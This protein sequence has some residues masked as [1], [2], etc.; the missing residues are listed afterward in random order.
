MANLTRAGLGTVRDANFPTN[1]NNEITASDLRDW[2]TDGIDSFLTQKDKNVM[3]EVIWEAKSNNLTAGATTDL[4]LANGNFVHITGT[5]TTINSFGICDAGSRF[6]LVF[7][8]IYTL[9]YDATQL[10]LPGTANITTANND[11]CMIMSEGSGN[12]RVVGYF[13]IAGGGGGGTV[14]AVTAT[15]P[16]ASSG[17]S[18]PDISIQQASA[19][20]D[21]YLSSTDWNTFDGKQDAL[22][23]G[24]GISLAS[25]TV[26]NTAPD[27][28]VAL[29]AGTAIST[30]GTYP[31]FTIANTAPDQTVGLTAGTGI[32]ITGTYPNFTIANTAPS[33]GG[34]V[35]A[36]TASSPLSS[37]G[38]T[39]P[40]ITLGTVPIA[41]GGT[42]ATATPT[43]GGV[44]YGTGTAYA[45][46]TAGSSGQIL[47]SNGAAAPSWVAAPAATLTIGSS[48]VSGATAGRLLLTTT[49]GANQ[50]LNQDSL[51]NYDTTN[52]RLGIGIASPTATLHLAAGVAANPQILLV[53]S[54]VTPSGTTNGSIWCN[55]ISSNT[56]L[57]MYKDTGYTNVITLDRNPDLATSG[58]GIIQA[59]ANGTL[60]KG[61][62]LTALGIFA[63]TST[64]TVA[65]TAASTTLI[66]AVTGV[67]TLPA[68]FFGV[69]KTIK[70]FVSGAYGC[71]GSSQ[72]CDLKLTI[73]GVAVGTISLSHANA[74]TARYY[75]AEFTLTCRT[76]GATGTLQFMGIGKI[77]TSTTN[78]ESFFQISTTSGSINTTGTLAIDLQADW[79]AADPA[80][81]ISASIL[82]A[83][84]LN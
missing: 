36:V 71:T 28:V 50:V 24:T 45:F 55:T 53:P 44:A 46:T 67:T 33:S 17:G 65:N 29:T 18:T 48:V 74:L 20:Q 37:S 10:I 79:V 1:N 60:S 16:L 84:Y 77:N 34:T 11:C 22:S 83:T 70:I 56:R 8:G 59:D 80:N 51:L 30:S 32:G 5:T 63:Q 21:G 31:N 76:A 49:S 64:V 40:N 75:D 3:E 15:T 47:Q 72:Q 73:G 23:A 25:N 57:T 9:D 7:K 81:T 35:T 14:T 66:G 54:A 39:T 19:S 27:Q 6:I 61:A 82:H 4:S 42:N 2:L 52:D 69:G 78:V 62:D 26:T 13:P 12:W 43:N 41:N 68:N 38:G 58:S